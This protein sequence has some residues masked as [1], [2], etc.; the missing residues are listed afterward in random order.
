MFNDSRTEDEFSSKVNSMLKQYCTIYINVFEEFYEKSEV[1]NLSNKINN[2]VFLILMRRF[3][4]QSGIM[5]QRKHTTS[6]RI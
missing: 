3:K 5:R 4:M 2:F 6:S 1:A